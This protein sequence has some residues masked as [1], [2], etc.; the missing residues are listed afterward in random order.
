MPHTV[1]LQDLINQLIAEMSTSICDQYSWGAGPCKYV[2]AKELSY[3][4]GIISACRYC[5]YPFRDVVHYK[6]DIQV[7]E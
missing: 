7:T 2:D 5:F 6:K 1:L 3:H 4:T